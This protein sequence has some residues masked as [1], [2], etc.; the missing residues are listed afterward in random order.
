[1]NSANF[2][3]TPSPRRR[4]I[5]L[6]SGGLDSQLAALMVKDQG[7]EVI[8]LHLL[9]PFGCRDDVQKAADAVGI[10]LIFKEKGPAYL[11]LVENPRFGYGKNMNPCID[12]RVFMFQ[13]ADVVRHELGAD[14]LVT[15][16]VLGQRPMSQHRHAFTM[17]DHQSPV[18]GLVVRPLSAGRLD[19]TIPEKEGWVKRDAFLKI[20]GRGRSEQIALAKSLGIEEYASPGGGCLLTDANFSKRLKDF[21]DQPTF[22]NE[23]QKVKQSAILGLGRYF[24]ISAKTR[25]SLGRNHTEN[26]TLQEK[27]LEAG[28]I[29][30]EMIDGRGPKAGLFGDTTPEAKE[31]VAGLIAYYS[32]VEIGPKDKFAGQSSD[33]AFVFSAARTLTESE[34]LAKRVGVN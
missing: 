3:Q 19:E 32:K 10:E 27:A 1:M 18:E 5:A 30:I 11:D 16:E 33:G 28:G 13:L 21:F 6:I 12:C 23:I 4:A 22:Q 26:T 7:I 31:W 9:S 8:G 2:P 20:S 29:F 24:R 14:F 17:I 15:G 34:V 25:V